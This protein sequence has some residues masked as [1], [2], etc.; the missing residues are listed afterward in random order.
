MLRQK[1]CLSLAAAVALATATIAAP[2]SSMAASPVQISFWN[3]M[4]SGS[5]QKAM[6]TLINEFNRTHPGIHVTNVPVANFTTLQQK[7][8]AS[9]AAGDPPTVAQA[10]EQW[11]AQYATDGAITPLTRFIHG[12]NGLTA[13]S[14]KDFFPALWQDGQLVDHQQWMLPFN[15]SDVVLFY[16]KAMFKA[17]HI[18]SPPSTWAQLATDAK[19]LTNGSHWGITFVPNNLPNGGVEVWEAM[20]Q[21]WGGTLTNA[22][23]SKL[24]FDSKQGIA[25]LQLLRSMV[26][27]GSMHLSTGY[28]DESDFGAQHAAMVVASIAGYSYFGQAAGNRFPWGVA[29]MP[30]GPK[31]AATMVLGDNL[32]LFKQHQSSAQ[33]QAGWAF[34]KWLTQTPQTMYWSV[35]TAY[36]PVRIS[37]AHRLSG[38]YKTHPDLEAAMLD[39]HVAKF[40][41]PVAAWTH[42]RDIITQEVNAALIGQLSPSAALKAAV[43]Q[44]QPVL[45]GQ[46]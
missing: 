2:V 33:Q 14:I 21:E 3:S 5:L 20:L 45:S 23:Y 32:V 9:I 30:A 24:T 10:F 17:A 4:S 46:P 35:Q 1:A 29:P 39:M 12:K 43:K 44:G 6:T 27:N 18:S 11:A 19:K 26:Q 42:V 8:L 25:P 13:S 7:T 40:D 16:N 34:M 37:A 15:K 41:P 28:G 31:S 38:Y 22:S 36:V